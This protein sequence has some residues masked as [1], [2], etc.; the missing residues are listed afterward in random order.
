MT[1]YTLEVIV[2]YYP[3]KRV[4]KII[5]DG[6]MEKWTFLIINLQCGKFCEIGKGI[7]GENTD[8]IVAKVQAC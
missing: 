5:I 2:A 6:Y 3:N 8:A 4:I 1:L 7:V